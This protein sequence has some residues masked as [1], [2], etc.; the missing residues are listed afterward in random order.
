MDGLGGLAQRSAD[1]A[2]LVSGAGARSIWIKGEKSRKEE[3]ENEWRRRIKTG[4]LCLFVLYHD[5]EHHAMSCRAGLDWTEL[6]SGALDRMKEACMVGSVGVGLVCLSSCIALFPV[7]SPFFRTPFIII[8]I[9]IIIPLWFCVDTFLCMGSFF[10]FF[11]SLS[12]WTWSG[13]TIFLSV[14]FCSVLFL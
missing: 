13:Y 1:R 6:H 5:H 4:Y 11:F 12:F 14:Q 8:I 9:I 7:A 2:C 10:F 3:S